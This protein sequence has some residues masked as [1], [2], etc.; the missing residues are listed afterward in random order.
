V[1]NVLE[2]DVVT[3]GGRLVTCSP[4]REPELFNMVLAGLG[5][6]AIIVRA[7]LRLMPAP[8]DVMIQQLTYTDLETY[9]ADQVRV[10]REGRYDHIRGGANRKD[11]RWTFTAELGKYFT[12]PEVPDMAALRSGL[13]FESAATP[14]QM[15]YAE[16]LFRFEG[17]NVGLTDATTR[18]AFIAL[19]AP[20][21]TS[22]EF[23]SNILTLPPELAGLPRVGGVEHFSLYALNTRRFGR[24]L[25]KMPHEEQAFAIWVFRS[26]PANDEA[27]RSAMQQSNHDLLTKMTALG[28][29]RYTPYS[30]IMSA[31]DWVTHFGPDVWRRLSAAKREYDP[32]QVLSPGAGMF[33]RPTPSAG[34]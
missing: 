33:G 7:R 6:C 18:R 12:P 3:G 17:T 2:L 27:A 11:G 4:E 1:D 16:N 28:G 23:V 20:A 22:K 24:P 5:Q 25:F 31:D 26:L 34:P 30:G 15:S 19:W 8:S 10:A 14:V 29:K 13:G 32:H 9:L 21:S